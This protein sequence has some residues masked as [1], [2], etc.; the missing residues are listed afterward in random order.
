MDAMGFIIFISVC[1]GSLFIMAGIVYLR[2]KYLAKHN[3]K[4]HPQGVVE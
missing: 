3:N 4:T 1:G 2:D